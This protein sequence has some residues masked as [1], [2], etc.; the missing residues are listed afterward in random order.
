MVQENR[1]NRP[2]TQALKRCVVWCIEQRFGLVIAQG[3][4]FAF[5]GF[6]PRPFDAMH[7]VTPRH[8]VA[9]QEVIE[10][11]GQRGELAPNGGPGQT[12]SFQIGPPCKDVRSGDLTKL[13]GAGQPYEGR[14]SV[15]SFW[16]ALRVRGFS[17]LANHS[18]AAGTAASC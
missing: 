3:R 16:Y 1:Q 17:M 5:V 10:E 7:R 18:T 6:D 9:F 8:C 15:R 11:A 14:K 12:A 4:G 2:V 13:I